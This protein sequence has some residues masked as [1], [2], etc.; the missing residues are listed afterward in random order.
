[1]MVC[2]YERVC[3]GKAC[4]PVECR[5]TPP[6]IDRRIARPDHMKKRRREE[7]ECEE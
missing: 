2:L 5:S 1:M 7:R 4:S 3:V 6:R